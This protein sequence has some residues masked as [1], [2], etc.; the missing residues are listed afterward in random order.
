MIP[1]S[2]VVP[3]KINYI[4][5]W[6]WILLLWGENGSQI[7]SKRAKREEGFLTFWQNTESVLMGVGAEGEELRGVTDDKIFKMWM[8]YPR[9]A[10][11]QMIGIVLQQ[12]KASNQRCKTRPKR[13]GWVRGKTAEP[14]PRFV[15]GSISSPCRCLCQEQ[16]W[17]PGTSTCLTIARA[18]NITLEAQNEY[19]I[20]EQR[21]K[22]CFQT[23]DDESVGFIH[24]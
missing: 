6:L 19:G 18:I 10:L 17:E 23:W 4:I 21:D 7:L 20:W 12:G 2:F 3:L 5:K 11:S 16:R 22:A 9:S 1:S 13:S 8:K 14:L 15:L 24:R